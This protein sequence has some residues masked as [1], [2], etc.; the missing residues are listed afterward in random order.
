M[1]QSLS[2]D[3]TKAVIVLKQPFT[4][5]A[6]FKQF[7]SRFVID[8]SG[9]DGPGNRRRLSRQTFRDHPRQGPLQRCHGPQR[10]PPAG[11]PCHQGR[12]DLHPFSS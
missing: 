4:Y 3:G 10:G 2:F 6:S 9:E 8:I 11:S 7:P 1:I 12:E 5:K